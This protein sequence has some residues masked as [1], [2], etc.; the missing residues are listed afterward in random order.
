MNHS[1]LEQGPVV[2]ESDGY[3]DA[4]TGKTASEPTGLTN[5]KYAEAMIRLRE[6]VE[7]IETTQVDVDDL[8]AAVREAVG[9]IT[10]CRLRLNGAQGAVDLALISLKGEID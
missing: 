8:D 10:M 4:Q 6:I 2:M 1:D 9:L 7:L 3:N 5:M